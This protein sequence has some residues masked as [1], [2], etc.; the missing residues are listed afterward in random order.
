MEVEALTR[1]SV[2]AR[3][4][5]AEDDREELRGPAR[6]LFGHPLD[7]NLAEARE[8]E[9]LPGIG[10]SRAAAIL[11]YRAQRPFRSLDELTQ[12][13]GIGPVTV[14]GVRGLLH[15]APERRRSAAEE[16]V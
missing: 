11:R 12:V 3:C 9:V 10:P 7:L 1:W 13:H 6:L 8:L 5:L 14:A 4:D 2:V 16:G 15:V